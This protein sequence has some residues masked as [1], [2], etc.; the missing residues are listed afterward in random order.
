M[1]HR[2]QA[3]YSSF[4]MYRFCLF[5]NKRYHTCILWTPS[6][7]TQVGITAQTSLL[8]NNSRGNNR[9]TA[10]AP[11]N[12]ISSL[13]TVYVIRKSSVMVQYGIVLC[14]GMAMVVLYYSHT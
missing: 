7:E 3:T 8:R 6:F 14:I 10:K 13:V 4:S 12:R 2:K 1:K 9:F 5:N 11:S